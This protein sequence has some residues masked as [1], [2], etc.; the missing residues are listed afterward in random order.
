MSG[1][2][3]VSRAD[4][5]NNAWKYFIPSAPLAASLVNSVDTRWKDQTTRD[6]C[7][8]QRCFKYLGLKYKYKYLGLKYKYDYECSMYMGAD[9][10]LSLREV[11]KLKPVSNLYL[12]YLTGL[13][14]GTV[15]LLSISSIAV[16]PIATEY[17]YSATSTTKLFYRHLAAAALAAH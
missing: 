6:R 12:P 5:I 17:F 10:P 16:I 1:E 14:I 2:P 13:V 4:A 7:G 11:K 15:V 3:R 9:H 8:D